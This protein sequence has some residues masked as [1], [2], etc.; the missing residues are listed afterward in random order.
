[1]TLDTRVVNG[2]F[3]VPGDS[4]VDS[5]T[6]HEGAVMSGADT[7]QVWRTVDASGHLVFP[8]MIQPGSPTLAYGLPLAR[9][10][11]TTAL[12]SEPPA[13]ISDLA[14]FDY[15]PGELQTHGLTLIAASDLHDDPG[16]WDTVADEV[17][18]VHVTVG[19]DPAFPL[20]QFLYHEGHINR[21]ISL[22]RIAAV[23]SINPALARGQHPFKGS[24]DP[25]ADGDLFVFDPETPDPYR[26]QEWPGRVIFSMQRG[27]VLLYNGELH[28]APGSGR[29]L[30]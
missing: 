24:F 19:S 9:G 6:I 2:R 13:N 25:G 14:C 1:M 11:T 30:I 27:E 3:V 18:A 26:E 12:V 8:G 20:I 23:T 28:T 10:G 5:L 17:A 21:G 4:A 16:L 29:R 15:F 7:A 22:E